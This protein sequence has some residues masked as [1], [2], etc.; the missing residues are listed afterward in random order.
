M[1]ET[2]GWNIS[3][4]FKLLARF[5]FHHSFQN[6]V[7]KSNNNMNPNLFF[8]TKV[9]FTTIFIY[10]IHF[11]LVPCFFP[12]KTRYSV[13][14]PPQ[15]GWMNPSIEVLNLDPE[16]WGNLVVWAW[17]QF[18]LGICWGFPLGIFVWPSKKKGSKKLEDQSLKI[19]ILMILGVEVD[20]V[21]VCKVFLCVCFLTKNWR[22]KITMQF[23]NLDL[24][25]G[26]TENRFVFQLGMFF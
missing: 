20:G 25:E 17:L 6:K 1:F 14:C 19:Q 5:F 22:F 13:L 10:F 11:F 24:Q 18:C 15:L 3:N 26:K 23:F 21:L 2:K 7:Q 9:L 4:P 12:I 8:Q 16:S